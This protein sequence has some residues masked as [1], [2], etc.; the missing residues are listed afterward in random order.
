MGLVVKRFTAAWCG[1]CRML[2]PVMEKISKDFPNVQFEIINID[3]NREAAQKYGIRSIPAVLFEKNG[4]V[5]HTL[6][7]VQSEQIIVQAIKENI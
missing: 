7:G 6:M 2:A 3:E 4:Q 1:P 5:V